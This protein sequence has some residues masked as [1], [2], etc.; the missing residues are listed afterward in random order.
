MDPLLFLE[1][2]RQFTY[3]LIFIPIGG[4][5]CALVLYWLARRSCRTFTCS[6][7]NH[8]TFPRF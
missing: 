1:Y 4:L 8:V 2:H 5:I 7:F 3:A 6:I